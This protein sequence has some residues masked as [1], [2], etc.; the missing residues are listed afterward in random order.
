M[1][2]TLGDARGKL[3]RLEAEAG[4][5]HDR[6][7]DLSGQVDRLRADQR[8]AMQFLASFG[9]VGGSPEQA[10]LALG[11][12]PP[13]PE[14]PW[15][16]EWVEAQRG[17]VARSLDD[18]QLLM[19]FKRHQ[20]LPPGFGVGYDERVIEFP[21]IFTRDIRGRV[22]D[23]GSTLNHPH[24]LS[25]IRPRVDELHIVT[26]TPEDKAYP[27]LDVSYLYEDLRS[28]PV[29]DDTYDYVVSL[30]TLEHIGMDTTHFGLSRSRDADADAEL[31]KALGELRRVL[32]PGGTLY[33]TVPFGMVEDFGWMRQFSAA[34]VHEL[35]GAFAPMLAAETF[36]RY[37]ESGWQI[38][39]AEEAAAARYRDH[40]S[41]PEPASDRAV[42]A[43]A[44]ACLELRK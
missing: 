37:E 3:D 4:G 1:L 35:I 39:T 31:A 18:P 40:L 30:S 15:T 41:D 23:A 22:L 42:A 11:D 29:A 16:P 17:Y 43:R 7:D 28:L 6:L 32:R 36:Y 26:L 21:W 10:A 24:V 13:A 9:L 14:S 38:S 44:V 20:P 33:I 27:F 25:R 2:T 8:G 12:Y 34:G 5:A 19:R